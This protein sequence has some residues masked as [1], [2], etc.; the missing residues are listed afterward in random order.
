M[1]FLISEQYIDGYG[2][3]AYVTDKQNVLIGGPPLN[4]GRYNY[5]LYHNHLLGKKLSLNTGWRNS[6]EYHRVLLFFPDIK[7]VKYI[8]N[9]HGPFYSLRRRNNH[10][11]NS[12]MIKT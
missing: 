6:T 8:R 5:E 12:R 7:N 1:V 9:K 11:N 4:K 2:W 3:S 10:V